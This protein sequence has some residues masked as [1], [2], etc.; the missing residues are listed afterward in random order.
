VYTPSAVPAVV[1]TV[2]ISCN[3]CLIVKEHNAQH[4]LPNATATIA[5]PIQEEAGRPT[6]LEMYVVLTLPVTK[7]AIKD[8]EDHDTV[9]HAVRP[10]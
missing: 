6:S 7:Q 1:V 5:W 10:T 9:P 2:W 4:L 3:R 8:T